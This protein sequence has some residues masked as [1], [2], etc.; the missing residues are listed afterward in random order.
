M[1]PPHNGPLG[2]LAAEE[3]NSEATL[4]N[5]C[6]AAR[7]QG[8]RA[9]RTGARV[10]NAAAPNNRYSTGNTRKWPARRPLHSAPTSAPLHRTPTME[11]H[12]SVGAELIILSIFAAFA[13]YLLFAQLA[14][15][16]KLRRRDQA[17]AG[18]AH[19]PASGKEPSS[20]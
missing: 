7:E 20:S 3:G 2:E 8:R 14:H 16:K 9:R 4:Y 18:S 5:W 6:R 11:T 1:L 10:E 19:Q 17:N 15:M 12:V 13:V